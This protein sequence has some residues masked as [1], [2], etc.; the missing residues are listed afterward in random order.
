MAGPMASCAAA[1]TAQTAAQHSHNTGRP[2]AS[3][4]VPASGAIR[5]PSENVIPNT[6]LYRPR[7][8]SGASA[9][10]TTGAMFVM[11]ISPTAQTATHAAYSPTVVASEVSPNPRPRKPMPQASTVAWSRRPSQPPITGW[12]TTMTR[13]LTAMAI[14]YPEAGSP[15]CDMASGSVVN[16][17]M[18]TQEESSPS[19]A[20]IRNSRSRN[21]VPR[22][23]WPAFSSPRLTRPAWGSVS[24][25]PCQTST[26]NSAQVAASA[27]NKVVNPVRASVPP[28]TIAAE[29]PRLTAQ[30]SSPYARARSAAGTRSA[31]SAATAGRYMS[32]VTPVITL[33]ATIGPRPRA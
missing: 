20:N 11:R 2:A 4:L 21:T 33:A 16:A 3:S 17:C 29:K 30:N 5:Y 23:S 7:S 12:A 9:A 14:P 13:P 32:M 15:A 19:S 1:T 27:Q 18:K 28:I 22:L 10:T 31:I 25:T 26:A 8:R 6:P 24:G